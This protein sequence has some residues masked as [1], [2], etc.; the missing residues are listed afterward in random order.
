MAQILL[1]ATSSNTSRNRTSWICIIRTPSLAA[2]HTAARSVLRNKII[3]F[4][5]EFLAA[6]VFPEECWFKN[7][8]QVKFVGP[9]RGNGADTIDAVA[10]V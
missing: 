10:N 3:E 6:L 7:T 4:D 9:C 5:C 2:R 8:A 1:N